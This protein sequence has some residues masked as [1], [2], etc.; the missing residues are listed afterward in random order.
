M[1]KGEQI[2]ID[3]ATYELIESIGNGGSGVVWKAKCNGNEYAIKF[4][5]SADTKKIKRF[6]KEIEFCKIGNHKSI[7]KVIA[8]GKHND[9]PCYVMPLYPQTL[10][11]LIAIEK[12]ENVLISFILKLCGALKYIH[13]KGIFHRDIKPENILIKGRNLVLAD[14]GIA[15]FKDFKLTEKGELLVNRNY[16][17]PEQKTKD[18]ANNITEAA[19]VFALGLII[20][21]CFT[22]QN[23]LGSDFKLIAHSYPLY[24]EL[25]NLV[26]NMIRQNPEDRPSVDSVI[27]EIKFIH[28]EIKQNLE[29]IANNLRKQTQF[30]QIKKSVLRTIIRRASEDILFGKILFASKSY[31][32]LKKY[33][34]NWHM[35]I[36]YAVDDFLF[37]LYVQERIHALC[38]A[39]FEYESYRYSKSNWHKALDLDN[40]EVHKSLY[41]QIN[42]ILANYELQN[43]GESLFDLSGEILKYFSACAD[44]HC[45]EI[46]ESIKQAEDLAQT[47][48]KNAPIIWIV[49]TLKSGIIQNLGYLLNGING[50]GGRYDFYFIE[51]ISISPE[52]IMSY[53][54][55][56]DS[57][58]LLDIHYQIKETQIQEILSNFQKKWK[59]TY[60]RIDEEKF[61]IKF[62]T[63]DQYEK[64]RKYALELSRPHYIFEGDVM[65]ILK[66]PNFTGNMVELKLNRIFDIPDTIAK[67]IGQREIN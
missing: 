26:T 67:I 57:T 51:H 34:H 2:N 29:D 14:F 32:E 60:N 50:L 43:N 66:H 21:E 59:V 22:K 28:H 48:L 62:K 8:D 5:N 17:A 61:S 6:E 37:N 25:D 63:Y 46:L 49:Q 1:K 33:N 52:R 18:N 13:K 15:H 31:K 64:F 45:K 27:T 7:I 23:P 47:N 41:Q 20:N 53:L 30:P 10:R 42:N 44:Y 40:N 38:K 55:N 4:I 56:D 12:D 19:D 35:K 3:Q 9:K 54:Y 65:D 39:K 58:E 36:G 16:A 11:D 24:A